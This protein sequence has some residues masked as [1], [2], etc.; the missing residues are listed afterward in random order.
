MLDDNLRLLSL[1]MFYQAYPTIITHKLNKN[2]TCVEMEHTI[3]M[4]VIC[5][6]VWE[7]MKHSRQP[8]WISSYLVLLWLF[9]PLKW[10]PWPKFGYFRGIKHESSPN[11]DDF[12]KIAVFK[13]AANAILNISNSSTITSGYRLKNCSLGPIL[14]ES[15]LKKTLTIFFSL[16]W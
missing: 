14:Q 15:T 9:R 1:K 8:S 3:L 10:I 4:Y 12:V 2:T 6:Y 13:M 7:K 5:I 16:P 11:F